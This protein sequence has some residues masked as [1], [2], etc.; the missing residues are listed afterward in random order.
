MTNQM[1]KTYKKATP[2]RQRRFRDDDEEGPRHVDHQH[3]R[4][5]KKRVLRE[6]KT[7]WED[8]EDGD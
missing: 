5:E 6:Y 7:H 3:E 4:T 8:L 1:G 2:Y